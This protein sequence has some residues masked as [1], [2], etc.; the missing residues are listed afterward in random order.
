MR[1]F[2]VKKEDAAY[3][4]PP[5]EWYNDSISVWTKELNL[6]LIIYTPG[7]L[8]HADYTTPDL[9]NYRSTETIW[10]SIIDFE[11]RSPSGLSGF[12][13]LLHI[14]THPDRTDK[15]YYRLPELLR[16]LKSK[17]Y[18]LVTINHLLK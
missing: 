11:K 12:I 7:I 9:K 4:L 8:S 13:L 15:F 10:N 2:G 3:F 17:N 18:E 6:Q 1:K 14:G 16:W 5:Y